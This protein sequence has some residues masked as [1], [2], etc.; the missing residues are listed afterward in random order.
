VRQKS[1]TPNSRPYLAMKAWTKV[2]DVFVIHGVQK[3]SAL[4]MINQF[5]TRS[6]SQFPLL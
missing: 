6:V 5:K 2:C 3:M 1:K 4:E